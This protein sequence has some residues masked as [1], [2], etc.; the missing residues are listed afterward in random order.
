MR[1]SSSGVLRRARQ[2]PEQLVE[3]TFEPA[4]LLTEL[5]QLLLRDAALLELGLQVGQ[6]R[7][8]PLDLVLLL[9]E[10]ELMGQEEE[11]GADHYGRDEAD[12]ER[13]TFESCL[14]DGFPPI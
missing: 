9:L 4:N 14:H 3:L 2:N 13:L 11:N 1:R 10:P 8:L 5:R 6:S 7:L 12:I